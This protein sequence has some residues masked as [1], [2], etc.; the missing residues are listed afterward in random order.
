MC[1]IIDCT[2]NLD[3]T[4]TIE[5]STFQGIKRNYR[6]LTQDQPN[7]EKRLERKHFDDQPESMFRNSDTLHDIAERVRAIG[8][9]GIGAIHKLVC[10]LKLNRGIDR[11]L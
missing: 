8:F 11:D 1:F 4:T 2:R 5:R 6:I 3:I 10:R 9:G 7:L